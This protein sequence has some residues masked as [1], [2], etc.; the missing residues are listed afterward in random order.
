MKILILLSLLLPLS[1][2]AQED[3]NWLH[4][5][6]KDNHTL[7]ISTN[8][9]Y[10]FLKDKKADTVVVA[11]I[12]NG[13]MIDHEDLNANIWT[14]PREIP[15]NG[16]DD[17]NNGYVDDIHGWNFL[18]NTQG[19]NLKMET[20]ELT[21]VFGH[22]Q[23]IYGDKTIEDIPVEKQ[24][25]FRLYQEVKKDYK[26]E[27][28]KVKE[29][30]KL[31]KQMLVNY[32]KAE[33][34][35]YRELKTD[36]FTKDIIKDIKSSNEKVLW[37]KKLL[38]E[39][40]LYNLDREKIEHNLNNS[41]KTLSTRLNPEFNMRK[42]IVRDEPNDLNDSIYGNNQVQARGP[43]HG[44]G[45]ASVVG[46]LNNGIGYS[47]VA[48]H[49][50]LMIIRIVP[51]GDER[52]KDIALA[53]RYAVRN[54]A[55]VINCS[56]GKKYSSHPEFVALAIDEA[57]RNNV[58]IVNASGNN[59]NNNDLH[60][61][62]PI[63]NTSEGKIAPNFITIGA[64]T[65]TDNAEMV[66]YFSNYGEVKVDV[67]AP[68]LNIGTSSLHNKYGV[69]SGTSVAAPVVTGIAAT[70]LSYYPYLSAAQL[71]K[72]IIESAYIPKTKNVWL[73]PADKKRTKA[74]LKKI[75]AAGGIANLYQAIV[76]IEKSYSKPQN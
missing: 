24:S 27:I 12:D 60:D 55:Q 58:L 33:V 19:K 69:S 1:L 53:I 66:A 46:A 11:I 37:A 10:S 47:G 67:L 73:P 76:L 23:N 43:S 6:P 9:A 48:R 59:A 40:Y 65:S 26:Q 13:A 14:N 25:E 50:K 63:C 34:I 28:S 16:I 2:F 5:D 52:D 70:L 22:L 39:F 4:L 74:K 21:R 44:T 18:G 75:C 56:F 68:G 72:I 17:D 42:I 38:L 64:S 62:Y 30:I 3:G 7:G 31:Y 61:Y 35:I 71:K 29:S 20:T 49:V 54:G 36:T 51:N 41:A 32:G 15:D 57:L 8:K 45:V